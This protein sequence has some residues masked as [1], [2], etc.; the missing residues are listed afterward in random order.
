[1]G[2][3]YFGDTQWVSFQSEADDAF[4]G[5]GQGARCCVRQC[6]L[7]GRPRAGRVASCSSDGTC[8]VKLSGKGACWFSPAWSGCFWFMRAH[9]GMAKR[10]RYTV[11]WAS[12]GGSGEIVGR[13]RLGGITRRTAASCSKRVERDL[14]VGHPIRLGRRQRT[15]T[16]I[17][18]HR[19]QQ[20]GRHV[21]SGIA[22]GAQS[23]EGRLVDAVAQV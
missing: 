2:Q 9:L 1:M 19:R 11:P 14:Q 5:G 16:D 4:S 20:Q 17:D 12:G 10:R 13:V 21:Q 8:S 18:L 3:I 15:G 22:R 7:M 6:L 23:N